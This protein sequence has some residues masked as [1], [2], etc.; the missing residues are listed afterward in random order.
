[1]S[2]F[3]KPAFR[4]AVLLS[5][6]L[7]Q[8]QLDEVL[9]KMRA[10]ASSQG[11]V[12]TD[13]DDQQLAAKL[14]ELGL[15]TQYQVAQL[16]L[17]RTKFHL[18]P[19]LITDYI[20]QGGMGQVFRGTHRIMGRECAVKV[21][22]LHKATASPDA[23]KNFLREVRMQAQ[24]DHPNLVRALDAGQEKDV[25]YLVTEYVP[26]MDLR[27]LVRS[28]GRLAIPEAASVILQT[29]RALEYAHSRGVVH[30]DVKPGNILV[31]P[32]GIAK[33]SDLGLAGAMHN[34]EDDPRK[35][36]IVGTPDY[37]APEVIRSYGEE[38]SP[39]SDIYSLGCSLYYAVCGKVP[40]PGGSTR[41]KA[42]RHLEDTA[43]HPKRFNENLDEEFVDLIADMME[44]DPRARIQTAA[45]V[46]SRL[47]T[48]AGK[49]VV[50]ISQS[51]QQSRWTAAPPPATEE[52][53]DLGTEIESEPSVSY[54]GSSVGNLNQ[55]TV[56][57][58]S[59][60]LRAFP[61]LPTNFMTEETPVS[62]IVAVTLAIAV[63]ISMFLGAVLA[64]A[65]M[66][67]MRR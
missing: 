59:G 21:L 51:A 55:E 41:D 64:T 62:T 66:N 42:R 14:I 19:Y 27:R 46:A 34:A 25:P 7:T 24:L 39:L 11:S 50:Q 53:I 33:L 1:M 16:E 8:E 17:G 67:A 2:G 40:F 60:R 10:H 57:A 52:A 18:G 32:D 44:K 36:R 61:I 65:L 26:G 47:E 49:G 63:P 6:L 23:I 56:V 30:R 45:E 13:I 12:Q 54:A 58:G 31:T 28:H 22:P 35:G 15:L 37:L 38:F 3:T 5:S 43:W 9:D 4:K 29:A 48:W 20:A